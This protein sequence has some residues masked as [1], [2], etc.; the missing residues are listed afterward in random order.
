MYLRDPDRFTRL[1]AKL[2]KG[3]ESVLGQEKSLRKSEKNDLNE[4]VCCGR[5]V[6]LSDFG[7][8]FCI[9]ILG[10]NIN[11]YNL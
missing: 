1:G 2:P 4:G 6:V 7:C 8:L 9:G 5:I 10:S 11:I 3:G